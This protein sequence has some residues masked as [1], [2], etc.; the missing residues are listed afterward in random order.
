M[1][2]LF[3][4]SECYPLVKTGGLAD[5]VGALPS[6]P[7]P[8]GVRAR[9]LLPGYRGL[10]QQLRGVRTVAPLPD[11]FGGRGT[12]VQGTISTGPASLSLA[13]K[14]DVKVVVDSVYP[15]EKFGEAFAK[16]ES[17]HAT[18]KIVLKLRDEQPAAQP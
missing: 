5:V 3:V 4:S 14:G 6:A 13:T 1:E 2:V 9:V 15:L 10:R 16:L 7:A 11:L 8:L 12:L 18:G 17:G